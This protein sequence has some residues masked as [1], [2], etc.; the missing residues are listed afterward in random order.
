MSLSDDHIPCP[1]Q[2]TIAINKFR[3]LI[4]QSDGICPITHDTII[5]PVY[6]LCGHVF[7][8]EA[9]IAWYDNGKHLRCPFCNYMNPYALMHSTQASAEYFIKRLVREYACTSY[10]NLPYMK[11][12]G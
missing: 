8:M 1:E 3:Y 7:E 10:W 2:Q 5:R 11:A 12:T 9:L 4:A 6:T